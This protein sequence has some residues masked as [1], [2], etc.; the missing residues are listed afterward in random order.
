MFYQ[1]LIRFSGA[2]VLI[3]CDTFLGIA[4]SVVLSMFCRP[5]ARP[6]IA[7]CLVEALLLL[8]ELVAGKSLLL[9]VLRLCCS[10]YT[11][12]FIGAQRYKKSRSI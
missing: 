11:F 12:S 3:F 7:V 5:L 6:E 10:S 8:L 4:Q 2:R 1:I 9:Q